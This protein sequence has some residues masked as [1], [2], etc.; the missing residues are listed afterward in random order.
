[1]AERGGGKF[2]VKRRIDGS[3]LLRLTPAEFVVS[4]MH[5]V[6]I[7]RAILREAQV[8]TIMAS[9]GQ[10]VIRPPRRVVG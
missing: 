3:V 10:T 5:A 9:P 2:H 6:E 1:M 8:E 4:P 7:A